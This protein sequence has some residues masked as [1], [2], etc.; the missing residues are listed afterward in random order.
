MQDFDAVLWCRT[1]GLQDFDAVDY[2]VLLNK[3]EY[4]DVRRISSTWFA[5][6]LINRNQFVSVN[7]D[8]SSLGDSKYGVPKYSI[9]GVLFILIYINDLHV[10]IE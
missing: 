10:V 8:K 3:P 4:Y 2:H 1:S 6:Y 7:G 9:K 5:S